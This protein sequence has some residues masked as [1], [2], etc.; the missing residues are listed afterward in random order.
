MSEKIE[1]N[2]AKAFAEESKASAQNAAFALKAE[3]EGYP[4]CLSG[5]ARKV[6]EG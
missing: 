5:R 3:Q 4:P 6:Q 2:I 1:K